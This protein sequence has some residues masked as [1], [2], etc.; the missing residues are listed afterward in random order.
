M[1]VRGSIL[2]I[3]VTLTNELVV[4][5]AKS[6]KFSRKRKVP[7]REIPGEDELELEPRNDRELGIDGK[8]NEVTGKSCKI[9]S[10]FF[11]ALDL[12]QGAIPATKTK[13]KKPTPKRFWF[14]Q[15]DTKDDSEPVDIMQ[16]DEQL[17]KLA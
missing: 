9:A 10:A 7:T 3:D 16:R 13:A 5:D 2:R 1:K 12:I 8:N 6:T 14:Y 11:G 4:A 15:P 17:G